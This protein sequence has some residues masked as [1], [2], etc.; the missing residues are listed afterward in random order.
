MTTFFIKKYSVHK[1]FLFFILLFFSASIRAQFFPAKHYPKDYFIYPVDA[2]ISLASNFGELRPN[3][4]HMG[5]DC[6][7]DQVVNRPVEAAADGYVAR[8]TIEPF[9][10]GQA[11]Y[12]N[13]PN[14]LTTVYGH[15][16]RFF[17]VLEKYVMEK[18]YQQEKWN[19]DLKFLPGVFPVKQGQFIAYSGSTGGSMG[20][21]TH[22]EIRDTKTDKVLN[23]MLFGLPIPDKVSPT[24]I[25]LAMYDRTKSTYSQ[26][27]KLFSL[28]KEDGD[29]TTAE[30]IIPVHSDKISFGISAND[31]QSG[32]NNPNGIFEAVIYLD[33]VPLSAFELDSISYAET[34]YVNAHVDYKTHAAGGP[35]IEHLSRL[36]GYP[37]G[38]YKDIN[39][40]GVIK[41]HDN[42]I[43]NVR[44]VVKDP[45]L[46]SSVL[47]FKIQKS[48]VHDDPGPS[49]NKVAIEFEP[50]QVNV[51]EIQNLQLYL[52]P[53]TLYDSVVF[54]HSEKISDAADVYSPIHSVFSGLIPSQDYFTVRIKANKPVPENLKDKMLIRQSWKGKDEV[55]KATRNGDWYSAKFN[56]FGDFELIAD[57]KSPL[58]HVDFHDNANLSRYHT[59]VATPADNNHEIKNFRAE[60]DGKWLMFTNDKGKKYIYYFDEHCD[61]GKHELKI[62]VEDEAGNKTE[63]V[64]HFTR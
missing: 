39:G 63:N 13:H 57:D 12:I 25:R 26:S 22:F 60:L 30:S 48:S 6:R 32:S 35:Y 16:N 28:K 19:V 24:I 15:L 27:P 11:V 34:R 2:R 62:S 37:Q 33:D 46:N 40:D 54:S 55:V 51:Y 17:P 4:Y 8:V 44:V 31:K 50:G 42:N 9:G 5:L 45:Y 58:V 7:T 43:H 47:N 59:I 18:Q 14:G 21:H 64:Y 56:N 61:A 23:E 41:L 38:V 53:A 29:Y 52:P 3:H 49:S 36:P 1:P 10:Y 20:P